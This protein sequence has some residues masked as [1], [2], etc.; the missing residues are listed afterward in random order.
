MTNIVLLGASGFIGNSLLS[1]LEK[2]RFKIK[3]LVHNGHFENNVEK[4]TGDIL[5]P[6][7][8]DKVVSNGDIIVNSIGQNNPSVKKFVDLNIKGGLN[9]LESIKNKKNIRI[10]LISSINVYVESEKKTI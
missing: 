2:E 5:R 7:L 1:S 3:A 8:L 10:I 9:I 6:G 4:F